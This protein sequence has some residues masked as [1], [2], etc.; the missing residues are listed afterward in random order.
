MDIDLNDD[1][2]VQGSSGNVGIGTET[3]DVQL[4]VKGIQSRIA[5]DT[6]SNNAGLL[7]KDNGTTKWDMGYS[8]G[9]DY[10]YFYDYDGAGTSMVIKDAT[11]NVGIGM[12]SPVAKLQVAGDYVHIGNSGYASHCDGDGDLHVEDTL[13]VNGSVW[14]WDNV[15]AGNLGG[16]SSGPYVRWSYGNLYRDTS[17]AKYKDDIQPLTDDFHRILDVEPKSFIDKPTG[18]RNIG[19]IAE[20]LDQLGLKNL[21][22]Y[23]DNQPDAIKYEM[24]SLYLLEVL[25]EQVETT[26]RLTKEN[27]LLKEQLKTQN[28]TVNQRLNALEKTIQQFAKAK[29]IQL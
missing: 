16:S 10:L 26:E 5:I 7:Y 25:K 21:V 8:P 28:K 13:N 6:T 17:S 19:F 24:V 22:Y 14:L 29:E 18:E 1:L 15:W 11:G 20:E 12:K 4:H 23:K 2:F 9:D 3:P 27:E